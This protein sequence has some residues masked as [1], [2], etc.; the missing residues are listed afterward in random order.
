MLSEE[1]P[2]KLT[3]QVTHYQALFFSATAERLDRV[4]PHCCNRI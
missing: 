1:L 4:R 3:L 2:E